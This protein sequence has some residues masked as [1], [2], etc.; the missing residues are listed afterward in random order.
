MGS[1][2]P[3]GE[4][5]TT[6]KSAEPITKSIK[7]FNQKLKEDERVLVSILPVAD[8]LTLALKL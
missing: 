2:S 7:E 6:K 3:N 5:L 8:G 1:S 4:E